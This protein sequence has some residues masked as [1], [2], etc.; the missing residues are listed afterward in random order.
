MAKKQDTLVSLQEK[1]K[2]VRAKR[3]M[4]ATDSFQLWKKKELDK[5]AEEAQ[6]SYNL[7]DWRDP[8]QCASVQGFLYGLQRVQKMFNDLDE[9]NEKLD[10]ELAEAMKRDLGR[11]NFNSA[12]PS[13]KTGGKND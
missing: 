13:H 4:A 12:V 1:H 10:N 5:V 3:S 7:A 2:L 11:A 9:Q 8:V 6:V